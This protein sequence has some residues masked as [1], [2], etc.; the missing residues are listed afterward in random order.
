M[1]PPEY[2]YGLCECRDSCACET[3]PGPAAWDVL[4]DGRRLKVCTRCTLS[5][6][7]DRKLLV[8][9]TDVVGPFLAYDAWG[10]CVVAL[11]LVDEEPEEQDE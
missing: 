10:M 7:A 9:K 8:K 11:E 5:G 3:N 1:E 6:D 4:R 2:P